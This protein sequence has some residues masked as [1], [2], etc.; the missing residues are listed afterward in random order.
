MGVWRW[1]VLIR[2][3]EGTVMVKKS[4]ISTAQLPV[5]TVFLQAL[6]GR[7]NGVS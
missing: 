4:M 5:L 2:S 3:E 6:Q 1:A 7:K